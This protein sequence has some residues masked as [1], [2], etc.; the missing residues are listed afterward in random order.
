MKTD[1]YAGPSLLGLAPSNK[2]ANFA[3]GML[4]VGIAGFVSDD[5]LIN[6]IDF[7]QGLLLG[8]EN[9]PTEFEHSFAIGAVNIIIDPDTDS[10]ALPTE[11]IG[12]AAF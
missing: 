7:Q 5:S 4:N 3:P 2:R 11:I 8:R 9:N 1:N 12:A 10:L 6:R